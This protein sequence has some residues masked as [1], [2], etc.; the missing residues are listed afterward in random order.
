MSKV[1]KKCGQ[2]L[3][4]SCF[5]NTNN[6]VRYPDEKLDVCKN[7]INEDIDFKDRNTYLR[8]LE[9]CDVPFLKE[10]WDILKDKY[11]SNILGRY[12]SKMKLCNFRDM[13]WRDGNYDEFEPRYI[14][15]DVQHS[16][17]ELVNH[18][19]DKVLPHTDSSV[20]NFILLSSSD[21]ISKF[22]ES[23]PWFVCYRKTKLENKYINSRTEEKWQT[24]VASKNSLNGRRLF[25]A[26]ID[27]TINFDLFQVDVLPCVYS[28]CTFIDFFD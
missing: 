17:R 7:C 27:S 16:I 8:V 6:F 22:E 15:R 18:Q 14:P 11:P 26:I 21:R 10:Q 1:C 28:Y 13:R 5:Y 20:G 24:M 9:E 3:E 4:E 25:R 12:L 23:H 19:K 2:I